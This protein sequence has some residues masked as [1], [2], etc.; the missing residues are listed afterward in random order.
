MNAA[1]QMRGVECAAVVH[2]EIRAVTV[3]QRTLE[4]ALQL[5]LERPQT[6]PHA[7]PHRAINIYASNVSDVL[8]QAFGLRLARDGPF[9]PGGLREGH[10]QIR[11]RCGV[12]KA[13][14][15]EETEMP[16]ETGG[17]HVSAS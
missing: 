3:R 6:I 11:T 16:E 2:E 13:V 14:P 8:V 17:R 10:P 5:R 4:V 1:V 15:D 7:R 9:G 12:E